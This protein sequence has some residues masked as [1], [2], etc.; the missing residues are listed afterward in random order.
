MVKKPSGSSAQQQIAALRKQIEDLAAK[1][2]AE[3]QEFLS[4]VKSAIEPIE[5]PTECVITITYNEPGVPASITMRGP[6]AGR[7]TPA[8]KNGERDSRLLAAGE[9]I[10]KVHRGKEYE[11]TFTETN[12][13][14]MNG[15]TYPTISAAARA[16]TGTATNGFTWAG[17]NK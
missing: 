8:R 7:P 9:T 1:A 12:A 6:T 11:I 15:T 17:L 2:N 14:V 5:C 3:A 13:V 16:A 4:A 10:R